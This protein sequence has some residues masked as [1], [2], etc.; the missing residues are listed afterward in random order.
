MKDRHHVVNAEKL[1]IKV[2]SY[3]I[4]EY[5]HYYDKEL[6]YYN[7]VGI[8]YIGLTE[9]LFQNN[10]RILLSRKFLKKA[11]GSP[12]GNVALTSIILKKMNNMVGDKKTIQTLFEN[13]FW[14]LYPNKTGRKAAEQ[15]FF[16]IPFNDSSNTIQDIIDGIEARIKWLKDKPEKEWVPDWP[17]PSTYLNGERWKDVLKPW[18]FVAKAEKNEIEFSPN[19]EEVL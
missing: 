12:K 4:L 14:K 5:M 11:P 1:K 2:T 17:N 10:I 3:L 19:K 15:A 8:G 13:Q 7:P 9:E 6:N 18:P 16:K